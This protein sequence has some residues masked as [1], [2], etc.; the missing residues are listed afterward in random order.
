MKFAAA[1]MAMFTVGALAAPHS[2]GSV[3]CSDQKLTC[4]RVEG[5]VDALLEAR[6]EPSS[7]ESAAAE[8]AKRGISELA[9]L[10]A[11]KA[12]DPEEFLKQLGIGLETK[13]SEG[14][15]RDKREAA[16][17][18]WCRRRGWLCWKRDLSSVGEGKKKHETDA[19]SCWYPGNLCWRAKQAAEV[20]LKAAGLNGDPT[21]FVDTHEA[22]CLRPEDRCKA[23]KRDVDAI[24]AVARRITS[25]LE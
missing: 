7:V 1:A 12:D 20:V 19:T 5:A 10:M 6:D 2:A 21:T 24:Q 9:T 4:L 3:S 17:Q 14:G 22:G 8:T 13:S 15:T 11:L 16:P 25:S 18:P 23:S